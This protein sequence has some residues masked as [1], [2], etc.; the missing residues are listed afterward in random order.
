MG[1]FTN[2]LPPG[3][4]IVEFV[5]VAPKNY[6]FTDNEGQSECTVKGI[7]FNFLTVR[8]INFESMKN[9]IL[10][11]R[12][13]TIYAPQFKFDRNKKTWTITT[14]IEQKKYRYTYGKRVPKRSI[15]I[16]ED[17]LTYPYGY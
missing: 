13:Q 15:I 3:K 11:D 4:W 12:D 7:T 10:N 14:R 8:L 16:F 17:F 1:E 5:A 6:G 2:E 9:I